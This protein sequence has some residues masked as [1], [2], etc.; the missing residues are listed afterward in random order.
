MKN[1]IKLLTIGMVLGLLLVSYVATNKTASAVPIT[2]IGQDTVEWLDAS[3]E[4][5]SFYKPGTATASTTAVF[6]LEDNDLESV[7]SGTATWTSLAQDVDGGE[8]YDVSSG[9]T[10]RTA[11]GVL[12]TPN[13]TS[14]IYTLSA[15]GYATST[16]TSTP[17]NS[18][19]SVT[20]STANSLVTGFGTPA[21]TTGAVST[22]GTFKVFDTASVGQNVVATFTYN[23]QDVY[24]AVN[25]GSSVTTVNNRV[26]V[27][28][29]SDSIGEWVTISEVTDLAS[30]AASATSKIFR[31]EINLS[32]DAA[33]SAPNDGGVW[34]QDGD[35]LT[36]TYYTSDH[37][38][39]IDSAT[40]TI[41]ATVPGLA[42]IVQADGAV[43]FD[44]SPSL[45]FSIEDSGSGL[46]TSNPQGNVD[47]FITT[48]VG[49]CPITDGELI[50]TFLSGSRIDVLYTTATNWSNPPTPTC[51]G[52]TGG[53]YGINT[54]SLGPN[55][56]GTAFSWKIVATDASG[57]LKTLS[58][59]ELDL[60]VD[61]VIPDMTAS[62]TGKGWDSETS[63]V[64]TA[65]NS[66][67]VTFN[68][69]LDVSTVDTNGSD[70]LVAGAVV[71]S[72]LVA[73]VDNTA[74]GG[75]ND[76]NEMVFLT[77]ASDLTPSAAPKVDM[78][79]SIKDKAGNELKPATGQAVADSISVAADS[80]KP[81][82]SSVGVS[83]GL[84]TKDGKSTVTFTSDENITGTGLAL[85]STGG[86]TCIAITG[87][88]VASSTGATK[89][90]V[91]LTTPAQ[92]TYDFDQTVFP[93]T[94]IYGLIIQARDLSANSTIVGVVAAKDEDVSSQFA[95]AGLAAN[96]A[97][98]IKI[99][100]WPV[101]DSDADGT[102]QDEFSVTI[103][104]SVTATTVTG[105]DWSEA[106][107]VTVKLATAIALGDIVKI[108]YSYASSN[109]QIVEVD[110][111]APTI[112][113]DPASGTSTED[114]QPF[115]SIIYDDDEYA[116]DNNTTVTVTKATLKDPDGTTTD[117]LD[118]LST[119]DNITFIYLPPADLVLG[120]Y[121][122]TASGKDAAGN[123]RKDITGTFTVKERALRSISLRPGWNLVS[124]AGTPFSTAIGDAITVAS[125]DTVLGYDPTVPGGWLTAVRDTD[126][127]FVGTLTTV[128]ATR[129]YWV[130]TSSFDP[131]KVDI[132]G[133]TAGAA[134]L[135]PSIPLSQG[136]N[137]IPAVSLDPSFVDQDSDTYLSGLKWSR[138]Y[139]W[140]T[141]TQSFSGFIPN[142]VADT[143][144]KVGLGYWVFLTEGGN[145][146]P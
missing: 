12:T 101:A 116:G 52:R 51:A 128:D 109:S 132:P 79:G 117:I 32:S 95:T 133:L 113:F 134:A 25:D 16:P 86:C 10:E 27:V 139:S 20:I 129:G 121:T 55:S 82:V 34:V 66:I 31:G 104:G 39:V 33:N 91:T 43:T 112:S 122:I 136:W 131:I 98:A 3:K 6:F 138:G 19:S 114:K 72:A 18:V 90:S 63:A 8:L 13:S 89:G 9:E 2:T 11:G 29:S 84:L 78:V 28:S 68:E 110:V 130:H 65:L 64:V 127:N 105:M 81:T 135:P 47:V 123:E 37:V 143:N 57:N 46:S 45:S 74:T 124:L 93:T 119:S 111:T 106:E 142:T 42:S 120:D 58:G 35:T 92:A 23:I 126:G 99:A 48:G 38:T 26:K 73:G 140:D 125:V 80:I 36:V 21:I 30:T 17:L 103:N 141:A 107:T 70:F 146:V 41:D 49:D 144:I 1:P 50:F 40:A 94:G 88:G 4:I 59:T 77:L 44:P 102:L 69:G 100:Q 61:T 24:A 115:I 56:H 75:T 118:S 67:Q 15:A 85:G 14:T 54:T 97:K 96:T 137:L 87:G 145:L 7:K 62:V 60:T 76:L 71:S 22:N 53:G 83:A 5:V 108:T